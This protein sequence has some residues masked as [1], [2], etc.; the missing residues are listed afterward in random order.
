MYGTTCNLETYFCQPSY[1]L[2]HK[3][4]IIYTF[5]LIHIIVRIK[6][7]GSLLALCENMAYNVGAIKYHSIV[8]SP[9]LP[10]EQKYVLYIRGIQML[11]YG[12][13][14]HCINSC[15]E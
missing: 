12:N 9:K 2:L 10:L 4:Q 3:C 11:F 8:F 14:E 6:I 5:T 7:V 1:L 13:G 15:T